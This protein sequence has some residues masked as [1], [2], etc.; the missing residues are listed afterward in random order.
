MLFCCVNHDNCPLA[1]SSL[2][3]ILGERAEQERT[4]GVERESRGQMRRRDKRRGEKKW[5]AEGCRRDK[6]RSEDDWRKQESR[7]DN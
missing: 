6:L 5:S 3:I 4:G 1:P 2:K 7:E